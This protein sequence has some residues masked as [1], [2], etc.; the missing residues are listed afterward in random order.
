M[1]NNIFSR[2]NLNLIKELTIAEFKLR[3]QGSLLGF[4]W[5]LLHPLLVFSVLYL[6][7]S[8]WTGRFVGDYKGYL[9]IGIVQWNF[10]ANTITCTVDVLVKRREIVKNFSFPKEILVISSVLTGLMIHI[11]EFLV[12]FVFLFFIGSTFS[13]KAMLIPAII[14]TQLILILAVSLLLSSLYIYYRD[15]SRICQILIMLG[16]FATPVFYS[17]S[18]LSERMQRILLFNPMASIIDTTRFVLIGEPKIKLGS[19]V[20][21]FFFSIIFFLVSCAVFRK[22]ARRFPE[23]I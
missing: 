12:L 15:I 13:P 1:R 18:M 22:L 23:A 2:K 4:L 19:L 14:A 21:V 17:L 10:F 6:L 3:D 7:F 20:F 8:K 9:L 5:T 11:L 16:F